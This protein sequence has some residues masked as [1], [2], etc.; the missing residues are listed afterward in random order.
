MIEFEGTLNDALLERVGRQHHGR[1]TPIFG[2]LLLLAGIVAFLRSPA[3]FDVH[4]AFMLMAAAIG[5]AILTRWYLVAK[6]PIEIHV[7][8]SASDQRLSIR[9]GEH[10]EHVQWSDFSRAVVG[11][12]FVILERSRF[13]VHVLG[14][15]FFRDDASWNE[16]VAIVAR[17]VTTAPPQTP[18]RAWMMVVLW[19]GI[20]ALA[21]VAYHLFH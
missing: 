8:G 4:H 2:A 17:H 11:P 13:F 12:D 18:Q 15:E 14:R 7:S 21:F 6:D 20:L 3:P 16:L 19:L 10:E 9:T 1:T 5:G